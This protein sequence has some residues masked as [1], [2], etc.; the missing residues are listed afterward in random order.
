MSNI[1]INSEQKIEFD[2]RLHES[3]FL[4]TKYPDKIPLVVQ[5]TLKSAGHD[6][7]IKSKYAVPCNF[8]IGELLYEFRK[9]LKLKPENALF[10]FV[11]NKLM[12]PTASYVKDVYAQYKNDDG[13]LRIHLCE[14]NVFG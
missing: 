1:I 7:K 13:F 12:L 11:N 2:K 6:G 4:K 10:I 9:T 5:L 14:E 8:T 3:T